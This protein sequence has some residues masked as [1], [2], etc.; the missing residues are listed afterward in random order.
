MRERNAPMMKDLT[1][2]GGRMECEKLIKQAE[3]GK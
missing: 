1:G 2:Y 3:H